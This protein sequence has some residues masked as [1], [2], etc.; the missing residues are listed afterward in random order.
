V[1]K[2]YI[3][4]CLSWILVFNLTA[5][6][7]SLPRPN[8]N[9]AVSQ[10][11]TSN[12]ATTVNLNLGLLSNIIGTWQVQDWQLQKNG[13]WQEQAGASWTFYAIHNNT[14]IRDEWKSNTTNV[15]DSPGFGTQ[16]R[17][18]DPWK[19]TWSAAW[20]SSRTRSL[21]VYTGY[22]SQSAVYFVTKGKTND[23]LTRLVFSEIQANSFNWQMQWSRDAGNTWTSVYKVQATRLNE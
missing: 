9:A 4:M 13:E 6:V 1:Q 16:L 2:P 23:R 20:L 11:G 3:L 8:T 19:K 14:A 7:S 18:Y 22:E 10:A 5:C 21:E 12:T 17:T 15:Q